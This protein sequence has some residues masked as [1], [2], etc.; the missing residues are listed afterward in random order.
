MRKDAAYFNQASQGLFPGLVGV[1]F[2]AVDRE[3]VDCCMVIRPDHLAI[4]GFL[5]GATVVTLADTATGCGTIALLPEGAKGHATVE[6]KCNFLSTARDGKL[7]CHA[8]PIHLGR[9][10]QVWDARVFHEETERNLGLFR[11]T[12]MILW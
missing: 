5:H 10:T 4:N 12:Q 7:L 9:S 2:L 11:C 3:R 1:E 8:V 6:L